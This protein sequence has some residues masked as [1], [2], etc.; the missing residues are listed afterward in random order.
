[1]GESGAILISSPENS[2]TR[3]ASFILTENKSVPIIW[4]N[5]KDSIIEHVNLDSA[6]AAKV[7]LM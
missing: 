6:K 2:D 1:M 5:E 7:N 4:T 3:L